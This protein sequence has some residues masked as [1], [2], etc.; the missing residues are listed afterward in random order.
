MISL[1]KLQ[2]TTPGV[3]Q[4]NGVTESCD[5]VICRRLDGCC[6][7]Y[8]ATLADSEVMNSDEFTITLINAYQRFAITEENPAPTA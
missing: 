5:V 1:K 4:G 7:L 6:H 3:R 8:V 2:V